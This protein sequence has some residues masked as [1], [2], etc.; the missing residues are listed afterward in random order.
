MTVLGRDQL[1]EDGSVKREADIMKSYC[2]YYC[3]QYY[4][5]DYCVPV[6]RQKESQPT[7]I[8]INEMIFSR[9]RKLM[10]GRMMKMINGQL[11]QYDIN[12]MVFFINGNERWKYYELLCS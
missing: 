2:Y 7:M 4:A 9:R 6:N 5:N 8:I 1:P 12:D 11:N 3:G 10:K